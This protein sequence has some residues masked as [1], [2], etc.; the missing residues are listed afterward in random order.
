LSQ[1]YYFLPND[2]LYKSGRLNELVFFDAFGGDLSEA[3][4]VLSW[5]EATDEP[6]FMD[7]VDYPLACI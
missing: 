1:R 4:L 2:Y 6:N 5:I 7:E 3:S